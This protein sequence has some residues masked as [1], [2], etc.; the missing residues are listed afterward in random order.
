MAF[1]FRVAMISSSSADIFAAVSAMVTKGALAATHLKRYRVAM[2][3]Q[4]PA[5]PPNRRLSVLRTE[6]YCAVPNP[7]NVSLLFHAV[8]SIPGRDE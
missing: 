2:G 8:N 6:F 4:E 7:K 3:R 1:A 5:A